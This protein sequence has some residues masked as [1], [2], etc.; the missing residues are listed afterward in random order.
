MSAKLLETSR[1]HRVEV[2][3]DD[4]NESKVYA[5][6]S[7][8]RRVQESSHH[9]RHVILVKAHHI[10]LM[11]RTEGGWGFVG[12]K[13]KHPASLRNSSMGDDGAYRVSAKTKAPPTVM[14]DGA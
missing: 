3:K 8:L 6:S 14:A 11:M 2:M 7:T 12:L 13:R 10:A 1:W 9:E 4:W 5:E